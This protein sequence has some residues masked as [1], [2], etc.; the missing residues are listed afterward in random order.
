LFNSTSVQSSG[1]TTG[2][3]GR[4]GLIEALRGFLGEWPSTDSGSRSTNIKCWD[5]PPE[6]WEESF[7][8]VVEQLRA[9]GLAGRAIVARV[10]YVDK[11][12][13]YEW[14]PKRV[15]WPLDQTGPFNEWPESPEF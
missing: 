2:W 6:R 15:V 7:Q 5:I 4:E 8:F 14:G 1:P 11:G 12:D 9:Q 10:E 13:D 3:G